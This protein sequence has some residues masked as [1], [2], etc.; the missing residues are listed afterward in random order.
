VSPKEQDDGSGDRR[1]RGRLRWGGVAAV[2]GTALSTGSPWVRTAVLGSRPYVASAF[3]AVSL[4][5]WLLMLAGLA[6]AHATFAG[7]FGRL[8]RASVGTTAVG[9]GL[10]SALLLRRVARFA[11]AGFRAVPATGEDPAALPLSLLA[12]AGYA[13]TVAGAGGIGAALRAIDDRPPVTPWLLLLAPTVPLALIVIDRLADLPLAVGRVLV[14]TNAVLVPFGLGWI[15]L[16]VLV[17]S[18]ARPRNVAR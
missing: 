6:S 13:L 15:A 8:G 10:V 12:T 17:W 14:S 5:G 4:A 18:R 16:G 1:G 9:M 11:D 3:D 2:V 7:R